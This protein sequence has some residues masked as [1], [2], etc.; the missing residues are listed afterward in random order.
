MHFCNKN[1]CPLRWI[2]L[3]FRSGS[4]GTSCKLA[5]AKEAKEWNWC[6]F[7]QKYLSFQ[8]GDWVDL[9]ER[10][11]LGHK[12][13]T[14]AS[15][16]TAFLISSSYAV[17]NFLKLQKIKFCIASLGVLWS[18]VMHFTFAKIFFNRSV[19]VVSEYCLISIPLHF[20][21]PC[22]ENVPITKTPVGFILFWIVSM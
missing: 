8:V 21:G 3:D 17:A 7:R 9:T 6:G 14:C 19:I 10:W 12:L 13:Q 5:P 1:I 18:T 22:S 11:V 16:S 4:I 20:F 15:Y 2:K